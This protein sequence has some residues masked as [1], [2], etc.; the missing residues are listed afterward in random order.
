M[1]KN[2]IPVYTYNYKLLKKS[3]NDLI[4]TEIINLHV[5]IICFKN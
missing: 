1:R 4:N 5:M 3:Q 2:I